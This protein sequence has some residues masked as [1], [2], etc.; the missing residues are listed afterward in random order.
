VDATGSGSCLVA[1]FDISDVEPSGSATESQLI[2]KTDTR[3]TGCE[4]GR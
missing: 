3:E 1:G 2:S 4:D